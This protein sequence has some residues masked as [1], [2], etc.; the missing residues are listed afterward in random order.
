MGAAGRPRRQ[1]H[2]QT[3][4][5]IFDAF[6]RSGPGTTAA[7]WLASAELAARA[8]GAAHGWRN[9][10]AHP[11]GYDEPGAGAG[12]GPS[13]S[14]TTHR[15]LPLV[16]GLENT[17]NQRD[18]P[19]ADQLAARRCGGLRRRSRYPLEPEDRLGLDGPRATEGGRDAGTERE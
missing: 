13:R 4:R 16:A 7:I 14:A 12:R 3:R 9:R 8:A 18:P 15:A 6:V 11:R 10:R 2:Q 17:A 5:T 19:G 1:R